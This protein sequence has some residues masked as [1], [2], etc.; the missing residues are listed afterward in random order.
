MRS[1]QVSLNKYL[2]SCKWNYTNSLYI[3][4]FTFVYMFEND[5]FVKPLYLGIGKDLDLN[6]PN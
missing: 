1:Q 5:V 3:I 2:Q 6:T 4:L